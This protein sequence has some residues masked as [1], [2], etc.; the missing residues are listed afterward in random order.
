M[1]NELELGIT[2]W[3]VWF[4]DSSHMDCEQSR[5]TGCSVGTLQGGIVD[6]QSFVPPIAARSSAESESNA[7]AVAAMQS[8]Y[9]RQGV[10]EI[11]TGNRDQPY[12][13]PILLI[14]LLLLQ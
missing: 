6:M 12:T 2:N 8:A 10:M 1:L 13:V 4:S 5:S 7:L 9:V 3:F 14:A 11:L